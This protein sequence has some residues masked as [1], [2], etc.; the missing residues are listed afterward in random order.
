MQAYDIEHYILKQTE[1]LEDLRVRQLCRG[2]FMQLYQEKEKD[3]GFRYS[4]MTA[5]CLKALGHDAVIRMGTLTSEYDHLRK[6]HVWCE[7]DGAVYD[8]GIFNNG[9]DSLFDDTWFDTWGIPAINERYEDVWFVEYEPGILPQRW[10]MFEVLAGMPLR[11]YFDRMPG[12]WGQKS[13]KQ[14][15]EVLRLD[16]GLG[17]QEA[18]LKGLAMMVA[19]PKVEDVVI[20]NAQ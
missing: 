6:Q 1:G 9:P 17:I 12:L 4:A 16:C 15:L 18:G 7:L 14:M 10:R 19:F 11:E 13:W 3:C 8:F 20:M 2:L 5:L